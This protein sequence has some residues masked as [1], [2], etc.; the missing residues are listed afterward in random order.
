MAGF[1]AYIPLYLQIKEQSLVID[2]QA[3]CSGVLRFAANFLVIYTEYRLKMF[4]NI[5]NYVAFVRLTW[6]IRML[7]F[8][9]M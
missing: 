2:L 4:R 6:Q 9:G 8:L 5:A 3:E 1:H 7:H